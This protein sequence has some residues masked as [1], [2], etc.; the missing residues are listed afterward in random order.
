MVRV[1]IHNSL[2]NKKQ[3]QIGMYYNERILQNRMKIGHTIKT[4]P[5]IH[6]NEINVGVFL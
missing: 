3:N 2:N 6:I 1:H 4:Y 5:T